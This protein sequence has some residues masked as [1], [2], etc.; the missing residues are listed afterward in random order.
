MDAERAF[1]KA[2]HDL[3]RAGQKM[4]AHLRR[5]LRDIVKPEGEKL[6]ETLA[7]GMP[8]RG[9]L[10]DRVRSQG[11][12]SMLISLRSG[13]KVQLANRAGLY[14]GAFEKGTIRHMLFGN[15]GHWYPQ[16]VPGNLA[17]KQFE[18]DAPELTKKVGDRLEQHLRRDL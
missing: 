17:S 4:P 5:D 16:T 3:E 14:V 2:A 15:R 12:V 9:G 11:R 6:L 8:K 10:A 1:R 13:V 7:A 18:K